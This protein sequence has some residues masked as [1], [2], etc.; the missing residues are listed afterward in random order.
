MISIIYKSDKHVILQIKTDLG[1][2]NIT[3]H[4]TEPYIGVLFENGEKQLIK[5]TKQ[6]EINE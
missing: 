6:L 4:N 1:L 5:L 2:L 3:I